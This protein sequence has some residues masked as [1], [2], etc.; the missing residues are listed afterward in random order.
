MHLQE[1]SVQW[2]DRPSIAKHMNTLDRIVVNLQPEHDDTSFDYEATITFFVSEL[3]RHR[4]TDWTGDDAKLLLED[5]LFF[6]QQCMAAPAAAPCPAV[7]LHE[8]LA[9]RFPSLPDTFAEEL[10]SVLVEKRSQLPIGFHQYFTRPS[11]YEI[12][13]RTSVNATPTVLLTFDFM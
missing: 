3:P 5:L 7:I 8:E 4:F 9:L 2:D 12:C 13:C 6:V 10:R 1:L 11:S